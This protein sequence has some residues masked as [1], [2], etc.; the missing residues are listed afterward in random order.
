VDRRRH[1]RANLQRDG[2]VTEDRRRHRANRVDPES[3]AAQHVCDLAERVSYATF[4]VEGLGNIYS[5]QA[6]ILR[7]L[8]GMSADR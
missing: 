6:E 2:H 1:R 5:T 7:L 8:E 3:G 4:V